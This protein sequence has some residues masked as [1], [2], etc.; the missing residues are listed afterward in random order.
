MSF[1]LTK[2]FHR[3]HQLQ[4]EGMAFGQLLEHPCHLVMPCAHNVLP[5]DALNVI[6]HANYL[7]AVHHTALFNSLQNTHTHHPQRDPCNQ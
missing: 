2:G 5:I 6:P 4:G 7:H 3:L 1:I